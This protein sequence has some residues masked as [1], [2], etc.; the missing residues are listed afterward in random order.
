MT[1]HW[2]LAAVALL[3]APAS[4]NMASPVAPGSPAGEPTAA[5][6]GLRIAREVLTIDLGPLAQRRPLAVVEAEYRIVNRGEART[7]PLDFLALGEGVDQAQV[8]LNDQP[9]TAARVDSLA[10]PALWRVASQTPALD[11]DPS[12]YETDDGFGTPTGFRFAVTIPS[13]QH[14]IRVAYRVRMGSYDDGGHPNR[15]WQ[16][17]YSLAPARLWAGFDQLD[18]HVEVPDGWD[19]ATSLPLRADGDALVGRFPGV[20]GD[21][22]AISARAPAPTLAVPLRLLAVLVPVVFIAFVGIVA[23]RLAAGSG[24]PV[25]SAAPGALIGGVMAAAA[26]VVLSGV[27]ADL[28]DSSAHGYS[29]I[30]SLVMLWGPVVLVA[31]TLLTFGVA[32]LVRRQRRAP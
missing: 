4:A 32:A 5:L 15:V 16:F 30:V 6:S 8:W 25:W 1:R 11:G 13:G 10:V 19:V 20:P 14:S 26:F 7:V 3:A 29:A 31:A 9:V 24:K 23:G 27:A 22:L 12:P 17:A 2:L 28:G 21:V 18:L